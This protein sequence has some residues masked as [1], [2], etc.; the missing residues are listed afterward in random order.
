MSQR[1]RMSDTADPSKVRDVS[2]AQVRYGAE[3]PADAGE[4]QAIMGAIDLAIDAVASNLNRAAA[5]LAR[6]EE[7]LE[8]HTA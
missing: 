7:K 5:A 6:I 4:D 2:E 1:E 3:A 8:A